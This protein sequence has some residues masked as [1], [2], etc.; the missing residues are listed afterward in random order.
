MERDINQV[1]LSSTCS[2]ASGGPNNRFLGYKLL[3]YKLSP[4]AGTGHGSA[5]DELSVAAGP[6]RVERGAVCSNVQEGDAHPS[7]PLGGGGGGGAVFSIP[8]Y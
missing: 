2:R 4:A 6:V 1:G 7:A 8:L 5:E 3:G